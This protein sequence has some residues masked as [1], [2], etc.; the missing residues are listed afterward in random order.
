MGVIV[1]GIGMVLLAA[2]VVAW[3][4]DR[5]NRLAGR[6]PVDPKRLTALKQEHRRRGSW[7]RERLRRRAAQPQH[8]HRGR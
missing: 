4:T 5:H 8:R 3:L 7:E 2:L 6:K 1:V